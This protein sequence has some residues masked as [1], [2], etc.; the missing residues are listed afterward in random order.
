MSIAWQILQNVKQYFS[1]TK[2]TDT[3]A[4]DDAQRKIIS[5][6]LT[7]LIG[8]EIDWEVKGTV[9]AVSEI[10]GVG[11]STVYKYRKTSP[12]QFETPKRKNEVMH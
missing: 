8:G 11:V 3:H 5:L 4:P 6:V 9:Q 1:D 7:V 2:A 12:V 10:L